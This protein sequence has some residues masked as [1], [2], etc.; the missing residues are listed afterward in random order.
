MAKA[1]YTLKMEL[2]LKGNEDVMSF[3]S[4]EIKALQRF[5]HFVVT[6]YI[7]SW[8]TAPSCQ[9]AAY[10]DVCLIQRLS[11]YQDS[12]ITASGLKMMKRHSW[13]LSPELATLALFSDAVKVEDKKAMMLSITAERGS[14]LLKTLPEKIEELQ[15]S[16]AFFNTMRI[17]DSFLKLPVE[18]WKDDP[19]FME[20]TKLVSNIPCVNDCA[21]RGVALIEDFNTTCVDEV[22]KQCLLQVVEQHRK[23]F[24]GCN[25]SDLL[26]I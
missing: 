25:R 5:N 21:E 12:A 13:Y 15:V 8:F 23:E 26:N 4:K 19:N 3:K 17:N 1:V 24:G 11:S 9:D 14:H 10:N 22:Q 7:Q 2:L 6:V 20:A 16:S 18:Q